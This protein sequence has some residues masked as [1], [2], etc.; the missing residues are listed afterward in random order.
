MNDF[1]RYLFEKNISTSQAS[2]ELGLS[3]ET[4]RSYRRG[5]RRPDFEGAKKIE[6]WS[7]KKILLTSWIKSGSGDNEI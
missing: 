3:Y 4:I 5:K 2:S 1:D 6:D 7:N